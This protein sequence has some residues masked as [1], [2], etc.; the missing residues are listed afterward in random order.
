M[1]NNYYI[2]LCE[3]NIVGDMPQGVLSKFTRLGAIA[4]RTGTADNHSSL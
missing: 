3:R 1:N 2:L 4:S